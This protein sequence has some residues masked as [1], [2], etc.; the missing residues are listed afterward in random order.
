[1]KCLGAALARTATAAVVGA[2]VD[3]RG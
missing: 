2:R 3:R 1:M